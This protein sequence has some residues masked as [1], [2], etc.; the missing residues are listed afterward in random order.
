L[1]A[2]VAS[3]ELG[4]QFCAALLKTAGE[5]YVP[6][7]E[8]ALM[9]EAGRR[10]FDLLIAQAAEDLEGSEKQAE[11]EAEFAG[12][13]YFDSVIKQAALEEAIAENQQLAAKLAEYENFFQT[14]QEEEY[15]AASQTKLAES[16]AATVLAQLKAEMAPAAV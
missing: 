7:Q 14:A 11:E 2:K 9:K 10:D 6:D 16:I 1:A 3:Y 13:E 4:R 5:Q 8:S 12:A 15:A